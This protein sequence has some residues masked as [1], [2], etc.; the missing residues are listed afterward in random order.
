M[1]DIMVERKKID[2]SDDKN[3]VMEFLTTLAQKESE[4]KSRKITIRTRYISEEDIRRQSMLE[5]M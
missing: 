2:S 5:K 3:C 4:E 1:M